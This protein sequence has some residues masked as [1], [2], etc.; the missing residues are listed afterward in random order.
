MNW[1]EAALLG[2]VQ[3]LTEFL[4]ISSSAH[5]RIVGSFLPNAADPGAA[6]TAITQLGTE[7]AVIVYFSASYANAV[8]DELFGLDLSNSMWVWWIILY[9]VFIALN[10]AGMNLARLS[11]P[12]L[13]GRRRRIG[14]RI[15]SVIWYTKAVSPP[16][17]IGFVQLSTTRAMSMNHRKKASSWMKLTRTVPM[18]GG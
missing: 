9:V 4:P 15:G 18:A 1:F 10:S 14:A 5:L 7:T 11:I 8:T 3:G 17:P 12:A 2:L 16:P 6:F 13:G